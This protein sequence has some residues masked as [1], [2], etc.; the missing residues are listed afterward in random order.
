VLVFTQSRRTAEYLER[1]IRGQLKDYNVARIDSRIEKDQRAAVLYSFC[2][3]YNPSATAQSVPGRIDVLIS[4]DV[5]SEGVNL[6]EAGAILNYDIHWNPVRLIQR[7]GRVDRRL[8]EDVT[9]KGHE[10]AI[11]NVLP[12]KEIEKIIHLVGSVE[13]RTLKISKALGI[14]VSFF[15]STDPA[16]NLKEFNSQYEGGMHSKDVAAT[17]Y[18]AHF[19]KPDPEL[20]AVLDK[21]PLG[22]FGVWENAP[23]NGLFALFTM[24]PTDSAT[25]ADKTKYAQVIGRPVF[26]MEQAGYPISHDAGAIL[27]ILS[28]TVVG[29][30]SGT[31]SDEKQLSAGLTKLKN[32]IR[33]QFADVSLPSTIVPKLVCWME[34]RKGG[35]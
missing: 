29:E 12:P 32:S 1:E 14:D 4:T 27:T 25:D 23:E 10:F 13:R 35:S 19:D 3:G 7:I 16:G 22:A 21:I 2:P 24:Q 8:D 33:Q 11:Y 6:Q 28:K 30:R 26:A 18:A 20:L 5:L 31:P 34:L 9:P 15:K 17:Q